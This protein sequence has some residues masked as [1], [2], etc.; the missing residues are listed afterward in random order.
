[1][2]AS[3]LKE[4]PKEIPVGRANNLIGKKFG[5][6]TVLYRCNPPDHVKKRD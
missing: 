3:I 5:R 2:R 4:L 6:L 1:M